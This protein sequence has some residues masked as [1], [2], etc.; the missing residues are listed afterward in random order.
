MTKIMRWAVTSIVMLAVL[1]PA[2]AVSAASGAVLLSTET[3]TQGAKLETWTYPTS[4]G[5]AKVSVV[6]VDLQNPYIKVDAIYG[7]NG[8]TG[9]KQSIMNMAKE[10]GAVAA[11]NGDFFTMTAEGAPFGVTVKS[12]EMITSPGY[13]SPKNALVIDTSKVPY[14]ERVDFNGQVVASDGTLFQLFGVNKTMYNAGYSGYTG[15]SHY[16]RLHMYDSN[17]NPANWVGD[18]LGATY[19]TVVVKNNVVSSILIN[20]A[21]Q[22]IPSDTYVLLAHGDAATWVSQHV[23]VGDTLRVN[24]T[25]SPKQDMFAAV[26]GSTLL[27]KNGQ[28]TPISYE[29]KGNLARTAVGYSFDKRYLYLVTVEK[30]GSSIGM[31]L[32]Q[33]SNFL[34]YKGLCDAVNFDGG[35]STT[36]VSRNLGAFTYKNAVTPQYGTQRAVPNG[37]AVFTT[38]PKGNL[39]NVTVSVSS[40]KVLAGETVSVKLASAYDVYYNPVS[41]TSLSVNWDE[42]EGV[43]ISQANGVSSLTFQSPGDYKLSYKVDALSQS[44]NV[45]VIEKKDIAK[46]NLGQTSVGMHP[47]E[48]L[49]LKPTI[50]LTDGTALTPAPKLLTW[51]LEGV[52]GQVSQQGVLT[53]QAVSTGTLTV[54]YDG[55]K[56]SLPVTVSEVKKPSEPTDPSEPSEP[57]AIQLKFF[58]GKKEVLVNEI[59]QTIAQAPQVVEGRTY[60]PLRAYA[61]LLGAYVEWNIKE[62]KVEIKYNGQELNFWVGKNKLTVDGVE[63]SIDAPPFIT[64]GS[65]MV[66]LRAAGEAFGMYIDY[67]KGV[68]SIT[69]TAK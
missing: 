44:F 53:A 39:K 12:G 59:S 4:A 32:D 42:V 62:Q 31:T 50:T 64:A 22:Q 18:S 52:Q 43:N 37:L 38:A 11:I 27:L 21:V 54:N 46:L 60:L 10:A 14:I 63:S 30:S 20:Q 56:V 36:M 35:G 40:K 49:T 7:K 69:V 8:K 61:E 9:N 24:M 58:L 45:H 34:L 25:L 48:A 66:P 15:K 2:A 6:E 5:T 68:Q 55:F 67:R 13:I 47:G 26:D 19:T 51:T 17:W 3:I 41:L 33:L 29:I 23:H 57:K 28:K 1:W 65:T 16:D